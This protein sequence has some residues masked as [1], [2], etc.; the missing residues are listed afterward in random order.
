MLKK[1]GALLFAVVLFTGCGKATGIAPNP[2]NTN[3]QGAAPSGTKTYTSAD[4][5]YSIAYP[6]S[7]AVQTNAAGTVFLS[8][9]EGPSD[10]FQ[11]NIGINAQPLSGD[12]SSIP[13]AELA[14]ETGAALEQ[15]VENLKRA[16]SKQV[17]I[18]NR[19][20]WQTVYTIEQGGFKARLKQYLVIDGSIAYTLTYTASDDQYAAYESAADA[21]VAT[22]EIK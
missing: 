16:E 9:L 4:Q 6:E 22:F 18:G 19:D 5:K 21:S 7:W 1:F 8:P 3:Q 12:A 11:E 17:K 20:A 10:A 13:L 15:S 2:Q 14:E